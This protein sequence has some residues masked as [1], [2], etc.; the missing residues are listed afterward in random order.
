MPPSSMPSPHRV[1]RDFPLKSCFSLFPFSTWLVVRTGKTLL[2][3]TWNNK[4]ILSLCDDQ[5]LEYR[6]EHIRK[7]KHIRFTL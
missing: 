3:T 6:L 1:R 2:F 7:F 4:L 5:L